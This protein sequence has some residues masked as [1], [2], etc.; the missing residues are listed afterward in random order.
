LNL[1]T[2]LGSGS[3]GIE[4]GEPSAPPHIVRQGDYCADLLTFELK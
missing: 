1:F 4:V 2:T 3:G